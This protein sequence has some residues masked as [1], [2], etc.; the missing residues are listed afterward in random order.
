MADQSAAP[1]QAH[2]ARRGRQRPVVLRLHLPARG[3]AAALRAGGP[4]ERGRQRRARRTGV[5]PADGKLD[6]RRPRRQPVRHRRGDARHAE[7]AVEPGAA[8]LSRGTARARLRAVA[9]GASGRRLQGFAQSRRTLARQVAASQRR[10]LSPRGIRHLRAADRDRAE[11]RC[12]H[13]PA[14][15]RRSRGLCRCRRVQDRSRYSLSLADLEQFGRDRARPAAAAAPRRRLFR[16]PPRQPRYPAEFRR[17][18]AHRRRTDR[19]GD[20]RHVLSGAE[21]GGADRAAR[22]RTAQ[23]AS[24][25]LR[26]REIQRGDRRRT[27][28]CSTPPPRRMPNSAAT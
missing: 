5:V 12:R 10:A 14:A 4:A 13:Y 24:A 1:D 20:A 3:A 15:G 8:L 25:D 18:R 21:R 7:A 27:R 11:A 6:R 22:R 26:L 19:C 28:A 17:A 2:R 9:G 23:R 16:L